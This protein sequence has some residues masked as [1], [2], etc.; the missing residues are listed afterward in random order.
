FHLSR[1]LY[2][3]IMVKVPSMGDSITEGTVIEWTKSIGEQV[4]VDDVVAVIETDKVSVDIRAPSAGVLVKTLAEV[5]QTV[6]VGQEL[7]VLDSSA[8]ADTAL[9]TPT[10]PASPPTASEMPTLSIATAPAGGGQHPPARIPLIKFLGKRALL[11][12]TQAA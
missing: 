6:E 7:L 8:A 2:D 12:P 4:N 5:D 9:P 3:D 11:P 1:C 10:A